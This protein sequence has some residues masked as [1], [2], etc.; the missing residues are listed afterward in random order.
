[1]LGEGKGGDGVT[2]REETIHLGLEGSD[3]RRG[4]ERQG[5]GGVGRSRSGSRSGIHL[6]CVRDGGSFSDWFCFLRLLLCRLRFV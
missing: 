1:L 3:G 5:K 2:G 6:S 4:I